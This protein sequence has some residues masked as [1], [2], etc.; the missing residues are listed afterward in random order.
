MNRLHHPFSPYSASDPL[1]VRRAV[2]LALIVAIATLI[3]HA[4]FCFLTR[5]WAYHAVKRTYACHQQQEMENLARH[6]PKRKRRRRRRPQ[7][8]TLA[9]DSSS[10]DCSI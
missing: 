4:A 8:V 7:L 10:S 9:P 2:A 3:I 5:K 6:P 1:Q